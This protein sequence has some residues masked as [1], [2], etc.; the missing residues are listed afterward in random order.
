MSVLRLAFSWHR[1]SESTLVT[2]NVLNR[3]ALPPHTRVL[4]AGLVAPLAQMVKFPPPLVALT[5]S[6]FSITAMAPEGTPEEF[7]FRSRVRLP[8][9]GVF[10]PVLGAVPGRE[11]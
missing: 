9:S 6:T 1:A 2:A 7:P 5:S 3:P 4:A 8:V 10:G 11:S